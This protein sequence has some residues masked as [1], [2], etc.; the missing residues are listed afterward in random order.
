MT[1]TTSTLIGL[2]FGLAIGAA[3]VFFCLAVPARKENVTMR[4]M[5]RSQAKVVEG[6]EWNGRMS[7]KHPGTVAD[8]MRRAA[9]YSAPVFEKP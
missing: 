2:V 7:Q 9:D 5:L 8:D 1:K 6:F 3:A 4:E